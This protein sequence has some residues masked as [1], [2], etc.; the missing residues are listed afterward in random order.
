MARAREIKKRIT[1]VKTIQRITKTMQM[2]ATAKFTSAMARAKAARP[3]TDRIARLVSEVL[4]ATTDFSHPLM[5]G[6]QE[7]PGRERL[8][9]I[10]SNRGLCGAYNANVLRRAMEEVRALKGRGRELDLETAGKK[11]VGYFKFQRI[12]IAT[13]H[14][15]ADNP[16]YA[17][18]EE[19]TNRFL[20]EFADGQFDS[21]GIVSMRF[22]SSARQVPELIRLLPLKPPISEGAAPEAHA[23]YE[24]SPSAEALLDDLLP[25]AVRTMVF[26]AFLD[27]A[28]SEQIMRM[29]AMRAATDNARD[30]GRQLNRRFNRA[31]QTQITTELMEV[32]GGAAALG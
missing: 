16:D 18:I 4:G 6:P 9:V 32:V 1:A 27:A 28:V 23:L 29:I 30:L 8:L 25:M 24:F 13:R 31:R 22:V 14:M 10:T 21:V 7:S 26:Q 12:P 3:Y 15:V 17:Q 19:L 20:D 11:A 5:D 2:I